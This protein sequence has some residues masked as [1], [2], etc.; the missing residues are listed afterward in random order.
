MEKIVNWL[1]SCG[2][3]EKEAVAEANK[4]IEANRWDGAEKCSRGYAIE[5]I[6]ESL[7]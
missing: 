6:L 2:Y 5:M 4:M 3:G 1:I 7:Q